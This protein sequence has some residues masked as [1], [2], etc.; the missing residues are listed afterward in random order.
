MKLTSK[1]AASGMRCGKEYYE[2]SPG[3]RKALALDHYPVVLAHSHM[4]Q[5]DGCPRNLSM[6]LR[7]LGTLV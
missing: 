1:L 5:L 7:H 6:T 3:E 2:T 4:R